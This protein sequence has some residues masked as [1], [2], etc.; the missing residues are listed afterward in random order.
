MFNWIFFYAEL[1]PIVTILF[2]IRF[3]VSKARMS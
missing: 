2:E 1:S 3:I